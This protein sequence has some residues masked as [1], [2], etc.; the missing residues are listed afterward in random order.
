MATIV[1]AGVA[2]PGMG[3]RL[4]GP[5]TRA[6]LL[7]SRLV[8]AALC[9]LGLLPWLAGASPALQALGWGLWF[10][11]SGFI[12]VGGWALLL[13]PLTLILFAIA[14][15][16]WFGS[17]MIV[18]PVVVWGGAA[19]SAA[20]LAGGAPAP[21]AP[22]AVPAL[23]ISFL[24]YAAFRR[25]RAADAALARRRQRKA[26]IVPSLAAIHAA[27]RPAPPIAEREL[28]PLDISLLRYLLD[29][30]LQPIG[31]LKGFDKID[32]FQTSAL[33]YQLN[34]IGYA[35]AEVQRHRLPN[36]RGYL[37]EG[38][39]RMIEQYLQKPIWGYWRLENLWGNLS[40]NGDP[41]RKD[42]IMLAGFLPINALFYSANTGD[43][44]YAAPGGL[45]FV[46]GARPAYRH[47]VHTI[48]NSVVENY[49][50]RYAQPF[51]LYPCEPNWIYPVCNMRGLTALRLYDTVY[52]TDHFDRLKDRFRASLES[53]FIRPDGGIVPLRSKHTGHALPFPVPDATNVLQLSPLYPDLAEAYWAIARAE[54]V[55]RENG[56]LTVE[57]PEKAVD[58]GNYKA[59]NLFVYAGFL[60][61]AV[62]MGDREVADAIRSTILDS[63]KLTEDRGVTSFKASNM[64]NA[65]IIQS[66]LGM[67]G[68]W[69]ESITTRPPAEA[70]DGPVLDDARYPDVL[71]AHAFSDGE[72][73]Q[74][75][76]YPGDGAGQR[77]ISLAQLRPDSSYRVIQ[78]G[79]SFVADG[80]GRARLSIRLDG[81]TQL[82]IVP[83]A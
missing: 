35:L 51:C 20:L 27:A 2:L 79:E 8:H 58:F 45:T 47:N 67:T 7:R 26:A 59:G 28:Q 36:F 64:A 32:Q 44:R 16:A 12:S 57:V 82:H 4:E 52:G 55:K 33:R 70:V 19:V 72:D 31:Q 41:A 24:A 42:N 15:V 5:V 74:L 40:P 49:E 54:S 3:Q 9:L 1:E 43:D 14:F 48:V 38:Q 39:R 68:G 30:A 17:G 78:T 81:R 65:H 22:Y 71:V 66:W 53:E 61:A 73:L 18:A 80:A 34:Q 60:S 29:R 21:F 13:V 6:R 23:T 62:E 63:G 46:N 10:P 56:K 69:R 11:G 75:V 25:S 76:L 50:G 37:S 83:A 77:D